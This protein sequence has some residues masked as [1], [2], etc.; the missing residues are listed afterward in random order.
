MLS[1][2]EDRV[3][4]SDLPAVDLNGPDAGQ[5]G[6]EQAILH[7]EDG[8]ASRAPEASHRVKLGQQ[9]SGGRFL[10]GLRSYSPNRQGARPLAAGEWGR[11]HRVAPAA[12]S[13]GRADGPGSTHLAL[14]RGGLPPDRGGVAGRWANRKPLGQSSDTPETRSRNWYKVNRPIAPRTR[15]VP[16]RRFATRLSVSLM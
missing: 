8:P 15:Q 14:G 13:S 3:R 5:L 6:R 10:H 9:R 11:C 16:G 2:P 7:L 1:E 4:Q 12:S